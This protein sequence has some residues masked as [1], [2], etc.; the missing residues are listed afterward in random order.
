[1]K[2]LLLIKTGSA[3]PSLQAEFGDFDEF[4]LRQLPDSG[5]VLVAPVV[6]RQW[7]PAYDNISGVIITG[8]H[9]MVTDREAWSE[10]VADWLR[11][12]AANTLPVLG[13]CYGH[14]LLAHA[15][16]GSVGYHPKGK[17]IGTV[18]INLTDAGCQDPLLNSMP[19]LFVGHVTHAQTVLCLPASATILARNEHEPHQAF[20]IN[21]NQWGV[22]FHPEFNAKI[23]RTYIEEQKNELILAGQNLSAIEASVQEHLYGRQLFQRFAE[24]TGI[25]QRPS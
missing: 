7:L 18:E 11:G 19:S 21:G 6:E 9:A 14:Q 2:P 4:V 3:F 5:A 25:T 24:L 16:G 13:I 10:F 1:M 22:Q 23:E 12:I 15:W 17:E 20:V 8:S